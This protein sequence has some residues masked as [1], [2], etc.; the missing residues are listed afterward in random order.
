MYKSTISMTFKLTFKQKSFRKHFFL[1]S[2]ELLVCEYS[3]N[4]LKIFQQNN[5]TITQNIIKYQL[6][7]L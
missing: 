5:V 1:I 6:L 2:V 3:S 4:N 7:I